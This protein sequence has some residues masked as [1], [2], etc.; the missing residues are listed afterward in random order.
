[1]KVTYIAVLFAILSG[2]LAVRKDY[3]FSQNAFIEAAIDAKVDLK[4]DLNPAIMNFISLA[5]IEETTEVLDI[6]KEVKGDISEALVRTQADYQSEETAYNDAVAVL[7][8]RLAELAIT[9]K[10]TQGKLAAALETKAG[11]ESDIQAAQDRIVQFKKDIEAEKARRAQYIQKY[12]EKIAA[13][14]EAD[15]ACTEALVLMD[16]IK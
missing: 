2:A 11:L 1:M 14:Q 6:L 4:N 9:L 12:E 3:H 10:T 8:A 13:L 7:E 16:D 5:A 15:T